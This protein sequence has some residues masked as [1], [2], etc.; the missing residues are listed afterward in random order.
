MTASMCF[1]GIY[2]H[3]YPNRDQEAAEDLDGRAT[4]TKA[5]KMSSQPS[6]K[7]QT[8]DNGNRSSGSATDRSASES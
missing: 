8:K 1:H 6:G 4:R 7:K 2:G 5:E 3:L